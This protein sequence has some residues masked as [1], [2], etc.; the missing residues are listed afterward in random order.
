MEYKIK[1]VFKGSLNSRAHSSTAKVTQTHDTGSV[2]GFVTNTCCCCCVC[3]CV[4]CKLW[5]WFTY[6]SSVHRSVCICNNMH[7]YRESY[8]RSKMRSGSWRLQITLRQSHLS[9]AAYGKLIPPSVCS[10]RI[11]QPIYSMLS[12]HIWHGPLIFHW[13]NSDVNMH[14]TPFHH[15]R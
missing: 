10:S 13:H 1:I 7:H 3:V 11:R 5:F 14:Q 12:W 6:L 4:L 15:S 2:I 8:K 9:S